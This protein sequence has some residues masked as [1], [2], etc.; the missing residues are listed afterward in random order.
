V[1]FLLLLVTLIVVLPWQARAMQVVCSL[2]RPVIGRGK[3]ASVTVFTDAPAGTKLTY[4]WS[5]TGGALV[6]P[7]AVTTTWISGRAAAGHYRLAVRVSGGGGQAGACAVDVL[8]ADNVRSAPAA[9][10]SLGSEAMR[11]LL[12]RGSDERAG[13]GLYSYILLGARPDDGNRALYQAV[14]EAY[15]R[16]DDTDLRMYF[17]I[18]QL[19]ATFVPVDTAP[20]AAPDTTWVLDHYD[21]ARARSLLV[22]LNIREG[23]GPFIISALRPIAAS[24]GPGL[25]LRQDLSLVPVSIVPEWMRLFRS[26]TTQQRVVQQRALGSLALQLHTMLAVAATGLPMV[27]SAAGTIISLVKSGS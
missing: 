2:D 3:A 8:V 19:N 20:T 18:R 15:L 5:A 9:A 17:P 26:Q 13:Y 27:Q 16:L 4:R 21:Y 7:D 1:R 12:V 24:D 22:R 11:D 25:Y 23:D 6:P 10:D 14:L